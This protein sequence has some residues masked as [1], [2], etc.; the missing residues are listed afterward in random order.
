MRAWAIQAPTDS[1]VSAFTFRLGGQVRGGATDRA[2]QVDPRQRLEGVRCDLVEDASDERR[3]VRLGGGGTTTR[4]R[5]RAASSAAHDPADLRQGPMGRWRST[6][7][8]GR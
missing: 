6:K 1:P 8:S 2:G 4:R 7:A 3:V 5:A